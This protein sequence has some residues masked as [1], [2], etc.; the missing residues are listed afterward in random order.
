MSISSKN[1]KN[2]NSKNNSIKKVLKYK[3]KSKSHKR[4]NVKSTRKTRKNI[5]KIKNMKGGDDESVAWTADDMKENTN[6]GKKPTH[7]TYFNHL[8][9]TTFTD[10]NKYR[11][12]YKFEDINMDM[13]DLT[14]TSDINLYKLLNPD[15][16]NNLVYLNFYGN[17]L[18]NHVNLEHIC[19]LLKRTTKLESLN[20]CY[21]FQTDYNNLNDFKMFFEALKSNKTLEGLDIRGNNNFFNQNELEFYYYIYINL[22]QNITLKTIKLENF[23]GQSGDA[24]PIDDMYYNGNFYPIVN[25]YFNLFKYELLYGMYNLFLTNIEKYLIDDKYNTQEYKTLCKNIHYVIAGGDLIINDKNNN[26]IEQ[27]KEYIDIHIPEFIEVIKTIVE[28]KEQLISNSNKSYNISDKQFSKIFNTPKLSPL[29]TPLQT[30][31]QEPVQNLPPSN[32]MKIANKRTPAPPA[33]EPQI[34]PIPKP[35]QAQV[36][37]QRRPAPEP[38]IPKPAQEQKPVVTTRRPPPEPPIPQNL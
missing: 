14:V 24:T 37:K 4:R 35:A 31:L 21:A 16:L 2:N 26:I 38:P 5:R 6:N 17:S 20:L 7:Q 12:E 36:V 23:K 1:K 25:N 22:I 28:H 3:S 15:V 13:F 9:Y 18:I 8:L 32:L 34:P 11:F 27:N 10:P 30:P 33:P 19:D 29:Q